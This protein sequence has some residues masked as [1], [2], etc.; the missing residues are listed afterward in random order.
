MRMTILSIQM[1]VINHVRIILQHAQK[2][3]RIGFL[4][5]KPFK[6]RYSLMLNKYIR[7]LSSLGIYFA[8]LN[9]FQLIEN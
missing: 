8:S 1:N 5:L 6:I 9:D 2:M 4:R 7:N 3:A